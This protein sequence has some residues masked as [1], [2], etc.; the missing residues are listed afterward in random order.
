MKQGM[1]LGCDDLPVN[2]DGDITSKPTG[3]IWP[4]GVTHWIPVA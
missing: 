2:G 4:P 3:S 1:K